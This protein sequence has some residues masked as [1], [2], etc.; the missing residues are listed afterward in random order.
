[1]E[2]QRA[3]TNKFTLLLLSCIPVEK[4]VGWRIQASG[5]SICVGGGGAVMLASAH[6]NILGLHHC[7]VRTPSVLPGTQLITDECSVGV[8]AAKFRTISIPI[9]TIMSPP[10]RFHHSGPPSE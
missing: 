8:P 10:A 4:L 3:E 1:M 9:M 6:A 2:S 7:V 5:C